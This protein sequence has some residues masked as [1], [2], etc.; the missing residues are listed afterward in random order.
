MTL[1]LRSIEILLVED[2]PG[3]VRLT[4]EGLAQA[5]LHNRLWTA[6]DGDTALA[7]LR[8][9]APHADVPRPDL[10]LLDL[11]LPG[12]S[13]LEV[14]RAMKTDPELQ[15]IPVIVL[16][17]SNAERDV[18]ASYD[19]HANCYVTKPVDYGEFVEVVNAIERFW[20]TVA[21]LPR[22]AS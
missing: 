22:V 7:M 17:S 15:R 8:R 12:T 5:A 18:L 14:L 16:S 13:G 4:Q 2:N 19:L 11:N 3:D 21:A 10:V 9:Q 6:Y 20:L 1:Q